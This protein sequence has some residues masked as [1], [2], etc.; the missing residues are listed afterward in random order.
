MQ[1]KIS[2]DDKET[3]NLKAKVNHHHPKKDISMKE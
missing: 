2:Q 3:Q 1:K